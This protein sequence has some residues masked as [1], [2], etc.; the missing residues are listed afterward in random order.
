MCG[1]AGFFVN[2]RT[3]E[4]R[5]TLGRMTDSVRHRGPDDEGFHIDDQI[6]LG[7]RR[8]SIIDL[9]TGQ[10]PLTNEDGTVHVI[11]NGE[12]YNFPELRQ[13]LER[14]GHRFGTRSD[15]EVIAHAYEVYGDDC[16][17]QL[18]GMFALA[19]WDVSAR[20]LLLARDRM[21]EKPLYYYS[22]PEAF[23]FGSELRALLA[24][25]SVPAVL[26]LESLS[27]YL[28]F[29]YIP[30][31][32]SI[33][34][35]V[36]KLLPGQQLIVSPGSKPSTQRYWDLTFRPE[37]SVSENEWAS[38]LLQRLTASVRRRM[39]SDVPLGMFLS[40]GLDSSAIVA[41]AARASDGRPVKTF[42]I[43]FPDA[44]FDERPYARLIARHCGAE[45]EE[46]VFSPD[47]MLALIENVGGLLDEPLV[48][49]SFLPTYALSRF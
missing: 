9:E 30:A 1:I 27:R 21:G 19:I 6:A 20:R 26:S 25:P 42:T 38:R 8:L 10:Q 31:P 37:R 46:T 2:G 49:G 33:F 32:Y 28:A 3:E 14:H 22:G 48:D 17:A 39:T 36:R 16:V 45:H 5:R 7:A 40:G 34:A 47:D 23:V 44:S 18:D 4:A 41:L 29:E 13:R 24:H 43:G 12:I 11:Q 15:T 35:G